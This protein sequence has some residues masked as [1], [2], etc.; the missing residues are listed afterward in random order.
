MKIAILG[1]GP[2]GSAIATCLAQGHLYN[3]NDIIISDPDIN[4]LKALQQ[5]FQS[6]RVTSDNR[7][8]ISEAEIIILA[9]NPSKVNEVLLSLRFSRS[10]ILVSLAPGI[11]ITHLAHLVACEMTIF[12]AIPNIALTE[13]AGMTLITSRESTEE[14]QNLI[15]Q[16]F[17]EGGKCLFVAEKQLDTGS[18]L[19]SS[20]VAFALKFIQA[21][22]QAGIELGF[23]PQDAMQMISYSMEG[24]TELILN[25]NS[26]PC[27]EIEKITTPGG[28]TIKGLNTLEHSNFTSSII[29]AIKISASPLINNEQEE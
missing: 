7:R 17:E 16:I 24:A 10:Q 8:A 27:L 21:A 29:Q 23:S 19:T 6:I 28:S 18:A 26:H 11:N 2:M 25:H 1:V 3:E 22:M 9:V 15:K 13:H 12:R 4:K 5:Y 14:Q 20:G